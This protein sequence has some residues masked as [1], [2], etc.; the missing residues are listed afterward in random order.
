MKEI[1]VLL[2]ND[3]LRKQMKN[4]RAFNCFLE[5]DIR[6]MPSFKYD[7]NSDR[8][9]TSKKARSPAWTDRILFSTFDVNITNKNTSFNATDIVLKEYSC[10]DCRHSDHRPVFA[11][12]DL[13]F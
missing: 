1:D 13:K 8:F 2:E 3:Q 12:F 10:F 11:T 5:G 9:D 7:K 6:F 4:K